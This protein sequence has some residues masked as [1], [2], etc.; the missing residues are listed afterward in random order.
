MSPHSLWLSSTS[1]PRFPSL[2]QDL[3]SDVVIVGAGITGLTAGLLL[4]ERGLR[5][6]ILERDS[7]GSGETGHTTAHVTTALD[8]GYHYIRRTYGSENAKLVADAA[9]A[10][11]GMIA[12]LVSRFEIHCH[13][14]RVDAWTYTEKRGYVAELKREAAAARESGL[15]AEWSE[16]VPLPFETR[17]AVR[18]RDQAQLH[19]GEYLAGLAR[20]AVAAGVQIFCETLVSEIDD[21]TAITAGGCV[22]AGAILQATNVPISGFTMVHTKTAPYRTYAMAFPIDTPR[23]DGLFWDTADPYHYIRCQDTDQGTYLIVGGEDHRVGGEE[24]SDARFDAL[25]AYARDYFDVE[26]PRYRWS[27]QII[28]PHGGLPLIG[29][30]DGRYIATGYSGQGITMGTFGAMLISDLIAG[31]ENRWKDLFD[32]SRSVPDMTARDFILENL[33]FPKRVIKDR[34]TSHDVEGSSFAT[35]AA[36]QAAI[37]RIDG[38]KVA[39]WRDENGSLHAVSAVCT[40][41]KCDVA[42]NDAERSWDCPCHGSRFT[43]DG[44]VLNGPASEPLEKHG[45]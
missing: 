28:E 37:L 43:P 27:G 10:S 44:D 42:W 23:H 35:L 19:A 30:S 16:T 14:R 13:F 32:P 2:Q 40:H 24:D 38:K 15:N 31:V 18:W 11:L 8:A 39:A 9:S 45:G 33:A 3:E 41:M 25:T 1:I 36:G 20:A 26:T 7:I 12:S 6:V 29:G 21:G 17:G 4:A 22:R 34:L 5:V